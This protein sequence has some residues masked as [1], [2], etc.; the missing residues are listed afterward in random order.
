[1]SYEVIFDPD[2]AREFNKLP[3]AQ[4]KRIGELLDDLSEK[5]RPSVSE[6][7]TEVDA[8]RIRVGDY[9]IIYAIRDESLVVLI[10]KVGNRRDVYKDI[11]IINKRLKK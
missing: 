7:L 9:R 6:K 5:P 8:Y 11:G 3:H 10:V 4:K 1:M 2:A